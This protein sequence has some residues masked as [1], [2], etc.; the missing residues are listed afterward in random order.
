MALLIADAS[1]IVGFV[2]ASQHPLLWDVISTTHGHIYVPAHVDGEIA[3]IAKKISRKALNNY[4]WM[5]NT[6]QIQVLPVVAVTSPI[7]SWA[8]TMLDSIPTNFHDRTKDLGEALTVAH[9][10]DFRQQGTSADV[11]IDDSGGTKFAHTYQVQCHTTV[12][13]FDEAVTQQRITTSTHLKDAYQAVARHSKLPALE[14]TGLLS[15][16]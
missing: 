2:A 14:D 5:K 16:V 13:V 15:R 12:W 4:N 3:R 1:P 8:A 10:R 7:A 6:Q 11:L 9:A